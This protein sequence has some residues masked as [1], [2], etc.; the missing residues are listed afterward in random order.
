MLLG[1]SPYALLNFEFVLHFELSMIYAYRGI[2]IHSSATRFCLYLYQR[3]FEPNLKL[4]ILFLKLERPADLSLS[5]CWASSSCNLQH[6]P[7]TVITLT[8][9][10][11]IARVL[12]TLCTWSLLDFK[13]TNL[14]EFFIPLFFYFLLLFF[15]IQSHIEHPTYFI[16]HK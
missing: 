7:R 3:G 2:Q 16:L 14:S 15:I 13:M 10:F 8:L 1:L 6:L 5:F 9:S 4:R 12:T 11:E